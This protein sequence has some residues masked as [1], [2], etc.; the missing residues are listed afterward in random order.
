[1]CLKSPK[2]LGLVNCAPNSSSE[3][4]IHRLPHPV[5]HLTCHVLGTNKSATCARLLIYSLPTIALCVCSARLRCLAR[6][7][8]CPFPMQLARASNLCAMSS[9]AI[10]CLLMQL[11]VRMLPHLIGSVFFQK[12]KQPIVIDVRPLLP[13][14]NHARPPPHTTG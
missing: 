9:H 8:I 2:S 14:L 10:T 11:Q 5:S 6:P 3:Y 12:K 7:A 13:H 1:M 4:Q